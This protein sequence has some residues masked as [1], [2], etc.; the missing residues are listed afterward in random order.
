LF[1]SR[2]HSLGITHLFFLFES[3]LFE[4]RH[5]KR[6]AN[7]RETNGGR[8]RFVADILM[9]FADTLALRRYKYIAKS[10][11]LPDEPLSLTAIRPSLFTLRLLRREFGR[12]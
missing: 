11:N 1:A 4:F 2:L 7:G 12:P 10:R 8:D 3:G 6:L 5:S 9:S